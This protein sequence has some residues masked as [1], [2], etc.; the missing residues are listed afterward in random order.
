[1]FGFLGKVVA[2]RITTPRDPNKRLLSF[3]LFLALMLVSY[4]ATCQDRK[5]HRGQ[6]DAITP[7]IDCALSFKRCLALWT[8]ASYE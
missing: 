3:D 5:R 8:F 2:S 7:S 4:L 6:P 1:M